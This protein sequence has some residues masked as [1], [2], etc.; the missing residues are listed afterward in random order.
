[1]AVVYLKVNIEL[2]TIK[3]TL[4]LNL[5]RGSDDFRVADGL[6]KAVLMACRAAGFKARGHLHR[7]E[8]PQGS[9][10]DRAAAAQEKT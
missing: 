7:K 5:F 4:S 3:L 8:R 10:C 9:I 6:V 1:M 2:Y